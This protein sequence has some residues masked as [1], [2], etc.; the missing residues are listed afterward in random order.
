MQQEGGAEG[1]SKCL[2][3][4]ALQHETNP[5]FLFFLDLVPP[6]SPRLFSNYIMSL[7]GR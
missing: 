6:A 5:T 7:S 1:W 4:S 2:K 3:T